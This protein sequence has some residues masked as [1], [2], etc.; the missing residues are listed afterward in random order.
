MVA[1]NTNLTEAVLSHATV[2]ENNIGLKEK[3]TKETGEWFWRINF[4]F[5]R[6]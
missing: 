1:P 2:S 6:K 5:D 3:F 4:D